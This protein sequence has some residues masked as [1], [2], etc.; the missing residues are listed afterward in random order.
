LTSLASITL[1][2]PSAGVD[3]LGWVGLAAVV[4]AAVYSFARRASPRRQEEFLNVHIIFGLV[5]LV[6]VLLHAYGR[7]DLNDPSDIVSVSAL[8]LMLALQASGV[9]LRFMP[10]AGGLRYRSSSIHLPAALL[11]Y[12]SLIHHVLVKVVLV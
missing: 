2:L 10:R 4:G 6:P 7:V 8:L 11:L 9:V 1:Q 5:A 12:L 3:L